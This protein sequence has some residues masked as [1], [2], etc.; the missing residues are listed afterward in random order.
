M[1]GPERTDKNRTPNIRGGAGARQLPTG[2]TFSQ[3]SL[4]GSTPRGENTS[5]AQHS[6]FTAPRLSDQDVPNVSGILRSTSDTELN[7]PHLRHNKSFLDSLVL[8]MNGSVRGGAAAIANLP[9]KT[10]PSRLL[11]RVSKLSSTTHASAV[12]LVEE[13]F[14]EQLKIDYRKKIPPMVR[15]KQFVSLISDRVISLCMFVLGFSALFYELNSSQMYAE[16]T[17]AMMAASIVAGVIAFVFVSLQ[18]VSVAAKQSAFEETDSK[19]RQAIIY[20]LLFIWY[21]HAEQREQFSELIEKDV[22]IP[23]ISQDLRDSLKN[24]FD[25]N[26]ESEGLAPD[27]FAEDFEKLKNI[28]G[29]Q[30]LK[31]RLYQ[32]MQAMVDQAAT[33]LQHSSRER[34]SAFSDFLDDFN[35]GTNV[36]KVKRTYS[37]SFRAL[38]MVVVAAAFSGL[39]G[40]AALG[41]IIAASVGI[42]TY[43]QH[44]TRVLYQNKQQKYANEDAVKLARTRVWLQHKESEKLN[45]RRKNTSSPPAS[46]KSKRLINDSPATATKK[47]AEAESWELRVAD[48]Q[49][50]LAEIR[51]ETEEYKLPDKKWHVGFSFWTIILSCGI[52][53]MVLKLAGLLLEIFE[54]NKILGESFVETNGPLIF[55]VVIAVTMMFA[56]IEFRASYN[57][58]QK[59]HR[60]ELDGDN[61]PGPEVAM[62]KKYHENLHQENSLV[63]LSKQA[64]SLARQSGVLARE[65]NDNKQMHEQYEI[66]LRDANSLQFDLSNADQARLGIGAWHSTLYLLNKGIKKPIYK[67]VKGMAAFAFTV[68]VLNLSMSTDTFIFSSVAIAVVMFAI[69]YA[70]YIIKTRE[71]AHIRFYKSVIGALS[72][73]L[74]MLQEAK[75]AAEEQAANEQALPS[76]LE[77]SSN[78]IVKP[79]S[80]PAS[81]IA[82][83]CQN[84][85]DNSGTAAWFGFFMGVAFPGAKA[86]DTVESLLTKGYN[87]ATQ[88]QTND[89][90]IV[91]EPNDSKEQ[92]QKNGWS[93]FNKNT[94]SPLQPSCYNCFPGSDGSEG[95]DDIDPDKV[96]TADFDDKGNMFEVATGKRI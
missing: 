31:N 26:Y 68:A 6:S 30:V 72:S 78:D 24:I 17:S 62:D 32:E 35:G 42:F 45:L 69:T 28:D 80:A 94:N 8:S 84:N 59:R 46:P 52:G 39:S 89:S 49:F 5:S 63:M 20:K 90:A 57:D 19:A 85:Y 56:C 86:S 48:T 66:R 40:Y 27:A 61:L 88:A 23:D 75:N 22:N 55:T 95:G 10:H 44:E 74:E 13:I 16:Y 18:L 91:N 2:D 73:D 65:M 76:H 34:R 58:T 79:S 9:R 29:Y 1:G 11:H 33:E 36:S 21:M 67:T 14:D 64:K 93:W 77:P 92:N 38:W 82:D 47:K 60:D 71:I 51:K 83:Y 50:R 70:E 4:S 7:N 12:R 25:N 81:S 43:M 15:R 53:S 96:P 37:P 3:S 41:M 87:Q 54:N